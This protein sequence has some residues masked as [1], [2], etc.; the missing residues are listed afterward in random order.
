MSSRYVLQEPMTRVSQCLN[1]PPRV[2]AKGAPRARDGDG[3][4]TKATQ[5]TQVFDALAL[6]DESR[7]EP[8]K[9]VRKKKLSNVAGGKQLVLSF[10]R[11]P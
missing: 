5:L 6:G 7:T 11:R 8:E 9:V 1:H 3:V 2:F 10:L 4:P